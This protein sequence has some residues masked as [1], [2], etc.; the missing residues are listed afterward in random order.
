M[1]KMRNGT[2]TMMGQAHQINPWKAASRLAANT[3]DDFTER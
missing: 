3:A 1:E 2:N